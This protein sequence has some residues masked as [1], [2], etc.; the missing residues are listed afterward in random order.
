M[1]HTYLSLGR[2]APGALVET[3]EGATVCRSSIRHPIGN[4]AIDFR[5][6]GVADEIVNE[7]LE[8][9][10][11]RLYFLPGDDPPD[12][13]ELSIAAG[14]RLRYE[15]AGMELTQDPPGSAAVIEAESVEA[16]QEVATFITNTFFW[17]SPRK[18]RGMLARIMAASHPQHRYFF[19]KDE[20]GIVAAGTL[21]LDAEVIGLYNLCVRGDARSRGVGSSFAAEL[22][23]RA[24]ALSSHVALLCDWGLIPWYS[25]QGYVQ[26][27]SLQAFG[28]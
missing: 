28:A 27:G 22:G 20:K 16:V 23:R 7:A 1:I 25:R 12:I 6:T 3:V 15:L 10:H 18:S 2:C 26:V 8:R 17:K 9:P 21:T 14:L 5:G 11:F 19:E 4:F 13:E 24:R